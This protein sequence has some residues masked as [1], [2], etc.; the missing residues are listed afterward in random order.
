M[1]LGLN[2]ILAYSKATVLITSVVFLIFCTIKPNR[3]SYT[4][5]P[6][7]QTLHNR[8]S[9]LQSFGVLLFVVIFLDFLSGW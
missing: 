7:T 4:F 6:I 5:I 2:S 9:Q 3:Q 8:E 1:M